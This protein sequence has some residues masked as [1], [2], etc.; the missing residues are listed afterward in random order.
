MNNGASQ[1]NPMRDRE[2]HPKACKLQMYTR[3]E[4]V[5]IDALNNTLR[6]GATGNQG[7]HAI[8]VADAARN[9]FNQRFR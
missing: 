5:W 2:R 8:T 4:Q 7:I 3:E 1:L 9:A 6:G